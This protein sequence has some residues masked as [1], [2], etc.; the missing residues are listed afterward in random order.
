M[1]AGVVP[2]AHQPGGHDARV[3]DH[4]TIVLPQNFRQVSNVLVL[5]RL[6]PA[7]DD[8]QPGVAPADRRRLRDQLFRQVVV[9]PVQ[10]R[11]CVFTWPIVRGCGCTAAAGVLLCRYAKL[12]FFVGGDSSRRMSGFAA[13]SATG[14]ASYSRCPKV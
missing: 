6:P 13:H 12:R 7:I 3:V 14:V 9:V 10:F 8:Q 1:A 2:T 11:H 4:Q 5:E